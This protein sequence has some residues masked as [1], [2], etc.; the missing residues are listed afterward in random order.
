[1][2]KVI[3]KYFHSFSI[4][5]NGSLMYYL[6]EDLKENGL[7]NVNF[8]LDSLNKENFKS[9]TRRDDLE[10]VLKGLEKSL[11][12]GLNVKLNT[13]IQKRNLSEVFDLIEFSAKR[14]LPI[15]FIELMPIGNSYNEDDFISEDALKSK[16]KEKYNLEPVKTKFGF[17]LQIIFLLRI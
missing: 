12:I 15:R 6:A 8:S 11:E 3:K 14:K 2:A 16:I 17:G 1:M 13:V 5:T 9:I 4:T 10:N 7:D